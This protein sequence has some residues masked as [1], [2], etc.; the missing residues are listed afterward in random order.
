MKPGPFFRWFMT[1]FAV[2]RLPSLLEG[3]AHAV[4]VA[5]CAFGMWWE[6]LNRWGEPAPNPETLERP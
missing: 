2:F 6:T 3:E 4:A 1:A 5:F